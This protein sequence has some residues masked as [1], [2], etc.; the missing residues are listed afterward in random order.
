MKSK[1][2]CLVELSARPSRSVL[3]PGALGLL[4]WGPVPFKNSDKPEL[5]AE[6]SCDCP[7]AHTEVDIYMY[8]ILFSFNFSFCSHVWIRRGRDTNHQRVLINAKVCKEV[9]VVASQTAQG[10]YEHRL[11]QSGIRSYIFCNPAYDMLY[12]RHCRTLSN[13]NDSRLRLLHC[14]LRLSSALLLNVPYTVGFEAWL[15]MS[16]ILYIHP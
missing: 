6:V 13:S 14:Y 10:M 16:N 8:C 7:P 1:E 3:G 2:S 15:S 9:W 11:S 12:S 5:P 4:P